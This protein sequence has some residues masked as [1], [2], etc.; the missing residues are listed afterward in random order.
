MGKRSRSSTAKM[1]KGT[2]ALLQNETGCK[3]DRNHPFKV[4]QETRIKLHKMANFTLNQMLLTFIL[5][6]W[7]IP[8]TMCL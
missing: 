8:S 6:H 2:T 1:F 3:G 5:K 7:P 4:K